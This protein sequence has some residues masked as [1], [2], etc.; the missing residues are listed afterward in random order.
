[1]IADL[2]IYL[3]LTNLVVFYNRV[4]ILRSCDLVTVHQ[5]GSDHR[6]HISRSTPECKD[7][8]RFHDQIR[9]VV[10]MFYNENCSSVESQKNTNFASIIRYNPNLRICCLPILTSNEEVRVVTS[11]ICR[12]TVVACKGVIVTQLCFLNQLHLSHL[13]SRIDRRFKSLHIQCL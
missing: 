1:M 11:L 6:E 9:G 10:N 7:H 13:V 4:W 2:I 12:S 3:T 5:Y 8:L